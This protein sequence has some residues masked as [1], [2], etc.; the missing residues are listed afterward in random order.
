MAKPKGSPKTGGRQKG[1]PNKRTQILQEILDELELD[2]PREI[3]RI[4]NAADPGSDDFHPLNGLSPKERS[5]ILLNLMQYLYPKRKAVEHSGAVANPLED[6]LLM[7]PEEREARKR[8][9]QKRLG[10]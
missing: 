2:V 1:T 5:D 9:L 10:K 6:Y 3:V 7:T 8:A 4:L